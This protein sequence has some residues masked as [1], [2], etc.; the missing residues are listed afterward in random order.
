MTVYAGKLVMQGEPNKESARLGKNFYS[1]N[2]R[3]GL[4]CIEVAKCKYLV[5]R[6]IR[7]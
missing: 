2:K 6:Q 3:E 7:G 1:L 4:A 5:A